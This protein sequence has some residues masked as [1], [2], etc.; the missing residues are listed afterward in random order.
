MSHYF[1]RLLAERGLLLRDYTQNTDGLEEK[2][3]ISPDLVVEASGSLF[4]SRC[5]DCKE[6]PSRDGERIYM[7]TV[8]EGRVPRCLKCRGGLLKPDLA[9]YGEPLP[10]KVVSSLQDDVEMCDLVLILGTALQVQPFASI[11]Q[12]VRAGTPRVLVN[13]QRAAFFED[14]DEFDPSCDIVVRSFADDGV[15]SLA[16]LLGWQAELDDLVRRENAFLNVVRCRLTFGSLR[17]LA[18]LASVRFFSC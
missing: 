18:L 13:H 10:E 11:P 7:S 8:L 2:A 17:L 1:V 14:T 3:G 12:C 6:R 4:S 9:F 15:R 16:S 5:V